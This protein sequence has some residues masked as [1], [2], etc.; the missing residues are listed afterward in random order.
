MPAQHRLWA[1]DQRIPGRTRQAHR[2]RAQDQ[3]ICHPQSRPLHRPPQHT[4]LVAKQQELGVA[5]GPRQPNQDGIEKKAK[6]RVD[7]GQEHERRGW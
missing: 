7:A 2:Q 1:H 4:Q 5:L 6:A 3:A